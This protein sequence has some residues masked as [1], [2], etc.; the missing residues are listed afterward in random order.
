LKEIAAG[1]LL[2]VTVFLAI[3]GVNVTPIILIIILIGG[4]YFFY[5][6][7]GSVK[8]NENVGTQVKKRQLYHLQPDRRT[9]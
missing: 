2:G 7:Q 4:F 5:I 6:A 8:F 1:C 9:G 3:I